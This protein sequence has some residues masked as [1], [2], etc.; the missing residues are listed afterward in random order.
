M[1]SK[2][3]FVFLFFTKFSPPEI[4][5]LWPLISRFQLIFRPWFFSS[6]FLWDLLST[7]IVIFENPWR[8]FWTLWEI[9]A[10][11]SPPR[12]K[13]WHFRHRILIIG[14]YH[15]IIYPFEGWYQLRSLVEHHLLLKYFCSNTN[16]IVLITNFLFKFIYF[17]SDSNIGIL[18]SNFLFKCKHF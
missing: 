8:W 15:E 7:H 17:Y 18:F 10:Q 4:V 14:C 13:N 1:I 3:K 12:K 16:V 5:T 2:K 9:W 6:F 11:I